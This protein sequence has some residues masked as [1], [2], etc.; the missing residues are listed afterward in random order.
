MLLTFVLVALLD[1]PLHSGDVSS[2]HR[3]L[4]SLLP[5]RVDML[6]WECFHMFGAD[7]L[8]IQFRFDV[9]QL[10]LHF[11]KFDRAVLSR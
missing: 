8:T 10:Q 9:L 6:H 2:C 5:H 4:K 7:R 11:R 3:H 1:F